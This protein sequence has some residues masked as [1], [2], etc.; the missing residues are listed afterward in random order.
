[1][2][3]VPLPY[4]ARSAEEARLRD[5]LLARLQRQPGVPKAL[6][7]CGPTGAGKRTLIRRVY[8]SD[9][10]FNAF[11]LANPATQ[12]IVNAAKASGTRKTIAADLLG[13]AVNSAHP[14]AGLLYDGARK[15]GEG[16]AFGAREPSDVTIDYTL[17]EQVGEPVLLIVPQIDAGD[18]DALRRYAA[19]IREAYH[20]DTPLA[21]LFLDGSSRLGPAEFP[22]APRIEEQFPG[23]DGLKRFLENNRQL[24]VLQ[25][26]PFS[27]DQCRKLLVDLGLSPDWAGALFQLSEGNPAGLDSLWR[28]LQSRGIVK[29]A[30]GGR[31][32]A[33]GLAEAGSAWDWVR[34]RVI[35]LIRPRTPGDTIHEG[36]LIAS[37][38][39]AASMG[40]S[41]LPQAVAECVVQID[42]K[43]DELDRGAWEDLWYD[44]LEYED[45]EHLAVAG[46]RLIGG[47]PEILQADTRQ[48]FVYRLRDPVLV[49]LI[50]AAARQMH[51]DQNA[52][53]GVAGVPQAELEEG[54]QALD[55]WL[56]HFV[57]DRWRDALGF[58]AAMLRVRNR[59]READQLEDLGY[60]LQVR[61]NLQAQIARERRRVGQGKEAAGLYACLIWY[62]GLLRELGE[63]QPAVDALVEAK[64]LA[65]GG[66]VALSKRAWWELMNEVGVAL[67]QQG[68]PRE[69]EP[70][71]S[72]A[73]TLA[74]DLY[75]PEGP[76]TL[77][78]VSNLAVALEE[79][80]RL[81]GAEQLYRRALE[82]GERVLGREHP[83]TL[84]WVNNL[85][86][87]LMARGCLEEAGSHFR[88][89][90]ESR[91]RVLGAE[92]PDTL[93][94]IHNVAALLRAQGRQEEAEAYSRRALE[95]R[96]RVLG[97]EHPD[98]LSTVNQLATL[99]YALG[100][101][102]EAESLCRR[103]L[104]GQ[105]RVLGPDHPS[106]LYALSNL[107]AVLHA[108]GREEAEPISQRALEA[109][110]RV[111]G[112]GHPD[113]LTS[114]QNFAHLLQA[115][116]R[117]DKAESFF[118]RAVEGNE[119]VLGLEHPTTLTAVSGLAGVLEALG[120]LDEAETLYLRVFTSRERV[121]GPEHPSTL[122]S[123]HD[124]AIVE[125]MRGRREEA[126][127]LSRLALAGLERVLGP[128]HQSTRIVRENLES[129]LGPLY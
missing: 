104:E 40:S 121:L 84:A 51:R 129:L 123:I 42:A 69:A 91:A 85:G 52:A 111:L 35:Q 30:G 127:R 71:L 54:L 83:K 62:G 105:G 46:P 26:Q 47:L 78:A 103:A 125:T 115:R 59:D 110:E 90:L 8:E 65:D 20:R 48:V 58:R 102:E 56:D 114:V 43:R 120:K 80:G 128:Q 57:Q 79:Q 36:R 24:E 55:A 106:T 70:L 33:S 9:R 119:R 113:T 17:L 11:R 15:L 18:V 94:A 19:L 126:E 10:R 74:T 41:F 28:V 109:R 63:Y 100:R 5:F 61:G 96:E 37:C 67:I 117:P 122:Y 73:L 21:L 112:P 77:G 39:L 44:F 27:K 64:E 98:T 88:R 60:R 116:G 6:V 95:A 45:P 93:N 76:E 16:G 3:P 99:E 81:E 50:R 97:P 29:P 72:D 49:H 13:L 53:R 68:N 75:G 87:V 12:E 22:S 118:R 25:L 4:V 32:Q 1:M 124:L 31:W 107:A 34:D 2:Q 92:H 23:L 86:G 108:Q 82:S 66:R 89:A 101:L 14:V 7:L 38:W